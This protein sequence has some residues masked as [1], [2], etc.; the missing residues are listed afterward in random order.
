MNGDTVLVYPGIYYENI[1][2][3][4]KGIVLAGTWLLY[5]ADSLIDQT[6]IDGNQ[7]GCCIL[8]TSGDSLTQ[9]IGLKLQNGV[10]SLS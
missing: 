1:N 2:L 10:E 9:L 8:S 6:I 4:G 7:T 3:T 5:Q